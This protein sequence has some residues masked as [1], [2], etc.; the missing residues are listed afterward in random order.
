[1]YFF[2]A[3]FATPKRIS[4]EIIIRSAIFPPELSE[5]QTAHKKTNAS[6]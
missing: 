2:Q 5:I 3:Q 6:G 4:V 1:M